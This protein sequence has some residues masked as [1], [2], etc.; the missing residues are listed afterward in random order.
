MTTWNE[1]LTTTTY[2]VQQLGFGSRHTLTLARTLEEI[3]FGRKTAIRISHQQLWI[4]PFPRWKE[5]T[6]RE[7]FLTFGKLCKHTCL[8]LQL[9]YEDIVTTQIIINYL[10]HP[11]CP[12]RMKTLQ[13][14]NYDAAFC[15]WL[16]LLSN[17]IWRGGSG[18]FRASRKR[19]PD[20]NKSTLLL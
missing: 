18:T 4:F 6:E 19:T 11:F 14:T 16:L 7:D 20:L 3:N 1:A 5:S 13:M 8:Y 10:P 17:P 9:N 2:L 15:S 12:V